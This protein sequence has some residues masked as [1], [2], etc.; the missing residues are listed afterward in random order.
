MS[1]TN[2]RNVADGGAWLRAKRYSALKLSFMPFVVIWKENKNKKEMFSTFKNKNK[3]KKWNCILPVG[4]ESRVTL[5]QWKR[6]DFCDPPM[7]RWDLY[8]C[9]K[10]SQILF[11]LIIYII[12]SWLTCSY[13]EKKKNI[14]AIQIS[15]IKAMWVFIWFLWLD[16]WVL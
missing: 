12:L 16:K 3:T 10:G 9:T 4:F 13:G 15:Y 6:I 11:A 7:Y 8:E 5:F 14:K 1:T 2:G